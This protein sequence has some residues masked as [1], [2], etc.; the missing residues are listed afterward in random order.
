MGS[1]C[2]HIPVWSC[3]V[4]FQLVGRWGRKAL[5]SGCRRELQWG[6]SLRL[7]TGW[8]RSRCECLLGGFACFAGPRCEQ[9]GHRN[10]TQPEKNK[11]NR[12]TGLYVK[13]CF[14][15]MGPCVPRDPWRSSR[16]STRF[17][18]TCILLMNSS[19]TRTI[20]QQTAKTLKLLNC[21]A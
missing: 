6:Q 18:R 9:T 8:R 10:P 4:I 12:V 17:L 11:K 5:R 14:P 15:T 19:F 13:Q 16:R 21:S 2:L 1:K 20:L 3:G 7:T